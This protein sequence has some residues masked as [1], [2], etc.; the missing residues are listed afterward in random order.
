[1]FIILLFKPLF[2][3]DV[4]FQLSYLAVFAIVSIDPFLY[5]LWKPK[6]WVTNKLWHTLTVTVSAQFGILPVSLYYFHQFPGLFFI[7]NLLIIPFLGIILGIGILI[8]LLAVLNILPQFFADF[9]GWIIEIM[10]AF[11]TWVGKQE[12]FLFKDIPFGFLHILVFYALLIT[13]FRLILKKNYSNLKFFLISILLVQGALIY[14]RYTK[15]SNEFI[16]F[17]KSRFS[18][19]GNTTNN[20]ILIASDLDSI[21]KLNN[22]TVKDYTVGSHIMT[23]EEDSLHHIYR[24]IKNKTKKLF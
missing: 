5:K 6:Y 18:L 1:M 2:I 7:S 8:I 16:V 15:P 17:H 4:G 11:V 23:I 10:N 12:F 14:T 13:F 3:F 21:S 19:L 20:K 22:N 9:F 24:L